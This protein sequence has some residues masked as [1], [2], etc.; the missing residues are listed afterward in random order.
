[1][2][3]R[4]ILTDSEQSCYRFAISSSDKGTIIGAIILE[5]FYVIF[6]RNKNQ[7]GFSITNCKDN[8]KNFRSDITGPS[9][10]DS[11]SNFSLYYF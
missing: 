2:Y 9:L 5:G 7:I 10:S 4:E 8:H 6:D 3:L 1:M 11:I